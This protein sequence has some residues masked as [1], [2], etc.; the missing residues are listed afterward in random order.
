MRFY[1]YTLTADRANLVRSNV[2]SFARSPLLYLSPLDEALRFLNEYTLELSTLG[3]TE[4]YEII[5]TREARKIFKIKIYE[6]I[7]HPKTDCRI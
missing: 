6:A 5:E 1:L 4:G 2:F 7:S 3:V